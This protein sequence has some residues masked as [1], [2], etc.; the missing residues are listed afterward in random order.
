[1]DMPGFIGADVEALRLLGTQFTSSAE[2]LENL[3][4]RLSGRVDAA[5]WRGPDSERFRSEWGQRYSGMIRNAAAALRG[6]S[7]SV[8]ANAG[9]QASASAADSWS[10]AINVGFGGG[11][12]SGILPAASPG[13][14]GGGGSTID[15]LNIT[16]A[17]IFE[18]SRNG[19]DFQIGPWK[20]GELAKL[21]PLPSVGDVLDVRDIADKL[22]HGQVPIHEMIGAAAGDLKSVPGIPYLVGANL[23]VWDSVAK[24]AEQADF[25]STQIATNISYLQNHTADAIAGATQAV[26]GF[27]PELF[28]D[29]KK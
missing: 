22:S 7:E 18:L 20:V 8:R 23:A 19:P 4:G 12:G 5:Q 13:W 17:Q 1:M 16:P 9:Q 10:G 2:E 28:N 27:L 11:H 26:V 6:A 25:S 24:A 29:L 3:V 21:L 14:T 15:P